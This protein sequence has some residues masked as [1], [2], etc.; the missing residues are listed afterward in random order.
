[1]SESSKRA[2]SNPKKIGN[3]AAR[4]AALKQQEASRRERREANEF[5][6]VSPVYKAIMFGLMIVG[7][8]WIVTFYVAHMVGVGL[9]IPNIG[10]WNILIGFGIAMAGFIMMFGWRE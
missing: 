5:Q 8:L 1:M 7:L 4:N 9:P 6:P 2:S 10:N 3:P